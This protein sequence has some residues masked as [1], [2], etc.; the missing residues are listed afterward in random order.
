MIRNHVG[1]MIALTEKDYDESTRVTDRL[2]C[3]PNQYI[4]VLSKDLYSSL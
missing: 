2:L 1:M 4:A 3:L